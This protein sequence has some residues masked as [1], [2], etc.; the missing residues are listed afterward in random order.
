MSRYILIICPLP[1]YNKV[2]I[3]KRVFFKIWI[4]TYVEICFFVQ[5]LSISNVFKPQKGR[6]RDNDLQILDV[7]KKKTIYKN[8]ITI[9][10][11][12]IQNHD[13]SLKIH[14]TKTVV[15]LILKLAATRRTIKIIN[16]A[17]LTHRIIVTK[18]G[19]LSWFSILSTEF[20]FSTFLNIKLLFKQRW[21]WRIIFE[22]RYNQY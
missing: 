3:W 5:N 9:I 20:I 14:A 4:Y 6:A 18:D 2:T 15:L 7:K 1:A 10:K 17:C 19:F 16:R 21:N 13:W 11:S 8:L 22:H 12:K